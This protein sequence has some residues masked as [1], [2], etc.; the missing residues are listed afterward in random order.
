M[1]LKQIIEED[2]LLA[3]IS[4]LK[5]SY[6]VNDNLPSE[7]SIIVPDPYEAYLSSLSPKDTPKNFTVAQ[8]SLALWSIHMSIANES[9]VECIVDPGS[10]I[11]AMSQQLCHELGLTYDPSIRLHMQ[12]ANG[13]IN[14]SLGLAR[15]VPAQIGNITL[16]LQIHVIHSPAYDVLL[17]RPFD[18]LTCSIIKN[19]SNEDQ[20]ITIRNPNTG[21]SVV[22]P[23]VPWSIPKPK[24]CPETRIFRNREPDWN[25]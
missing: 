5:N 22:I 12:S 9:S 20:T 15:N 21:K 11:I 16:Y 7:A 24:P 8:E 4:T 3:S 19:Y 6:S 2:D 25:I 1:A 10:Q 13:E 14:R 17:G 18:V 23:T